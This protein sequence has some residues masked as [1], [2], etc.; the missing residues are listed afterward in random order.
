MSC[1]KINNTNLNLTIDT[2]LLLLLLPM[3][4]IGFIM[5]SVL[6]SGAERLAIYGA[7]VELAFWGLT[8]HE[9]GTVHLYISLAFMAILLLH[10]IMHWTAIQIWFRKLLPNKSIRTLIAILAIVAVLL[11]LLGPFMIKPETVP[12]TP[13]YRNR[14]LHNLSDESSNRGHAL[15][16]FPGVQYNKNKNI[17]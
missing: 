2:I 3:A 15:R 10:I 14:S 17:K 4:G 7:D 12:F 1:G 8:H 13:H 9:W 16:E 11:S 6:L 5:K